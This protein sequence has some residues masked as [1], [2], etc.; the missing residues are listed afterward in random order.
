MK[1]E[2]HKSAPME[3]RASIGSFNDETRSVTVT[4]STGA[5]VRRVP[6]FSEPFH[7]ELSMERGAVDMTRMNNGAPV[8]DNHRR[9]GESIT[10]PDKPLVIGVVENARLEKGNLVHEIRF[11]KRK[12]LDPFVQD[13]KDGIVRNVSTGFDILENVELPQ[14]ASDGFR[15]FRAVKWQPM[16][17]SFTPVGADAGSVTRSEPETENYSNCEFHFINE[18]N[19]DLETTPEKKPEA[20]PSTGPETRTEPVAKAP[21]AHVSTEPTPDLDQIRREAVEAERTRSIEIRAAVSSAKLESSVADDFITLGA[22][23]NSVRKDVLGMLAAKDAKTE[24]HSTRTEVG[25]NLDKVGL[26]KGITEALLH[27]CDSANNKL[28]EVSKGFAHRS[29]IN[30]ASDV[31]E[32]EGVN[33]RGMRPMEIATRG[34][35][36]TSDFPLLLADV[37]NKT[38]RRAYNESPQSFAPFTRRVT[39]PDFKDINRMQLGDGPSLEKKLENGEYR[40]GTIGEA[41]EV[42]SVEEYG[43]ILP[44]GRRVLINDDLDAF[45]RL[46]AIMGRRARDLESDLV[47][48]VITSNP[49]MA[50]GNALFSNAHNNLGTAAAMSEATLTEA[51]KL[52]RLQLGLGGAKLNIIPRWLFVP[53]AL[54]T[55][56]EKL[57]STITPNTTDD[58]NVFGPGGTTPLRH[59]VEPRLDDNSA[60]SHYVFADQAQID[61]LEL[62]TLEGE[63]EPVVDSDINFNTDGMRFKIRHTVGVKAIDFRGVVKNVGA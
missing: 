46:P 53:V 38:L 60:L 56:A 23:I 12:S 5:R 11:S 1:I 16:E 18:R 55:A 6:F 3:C 4:A 2:N 52:M 27:R 62:A 21:V 28:S 34:L 7:Q 14:R 50:D 13:V 61:I 48:L 36:S 59:G 51:R 17:T 43:K 63:T 15:V 37:T 42:Y 25:E 9:L 32:S 39:T 24:T 30:L 54:E 44:I 10:D 29:L 19:M 47:W 31:L 40:S 35:H 20:A 22:D 58:T 26:H 33:T 45:S 57:L 41:A 49:L 8:L